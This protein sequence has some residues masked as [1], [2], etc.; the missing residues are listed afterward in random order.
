MSSIAHI[1]H[2]QRFELFGEILYLCGSMIFMYDA[3]HPYTS[4]TYLAGTILYG[5]GSCSMLIQSVLTLWIP[6]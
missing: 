4:P 1:K 5:V 3:L 6:G 2:A